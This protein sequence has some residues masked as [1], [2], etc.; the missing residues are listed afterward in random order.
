M[1]N[2]EANDLSRPATQR[3]HS[4]SERDEALFPAHIVCGGLI[5]QDRILS[6]GRRCAI[7]SWL[8]SSGLPSL[9]MPGLERVKKHL[10]FWFVKVLSY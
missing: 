8:P 10:G 2:T 7:L 5:F 6:L 1:C 3:I 4:L 9:K